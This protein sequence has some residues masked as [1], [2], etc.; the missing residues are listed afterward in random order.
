EAVGDGQRQALDLPEEAA[1][2]V[3]RRVG[4]AAEAA[5][6]RT[7]HQLLRDDALPRVRLP[8]DEDQ[9]SLRDAA[10]HLLVDLGAAGRDDAELP[11]VYR[12]RHASSPMSARASRPRRAASLR[13]TPLL[14]TANRP[15]AGE[16]LYSPFFIGGGAPRFRFRPRPAP[17]RAPAPTSS[18]QLPACS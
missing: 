4:R 12:C 14:G 3:L 16:G 8:L 18:L 17:P 9:R 11:L 13:R 5:V 1:R 15:P 6:Q 7:V 10:A 2:R